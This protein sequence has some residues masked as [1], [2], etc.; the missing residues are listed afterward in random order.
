MTVD[1]ARE[2]LFQNARLRFPNGKGMPT[3]TKIEALED[4]ISDFAI[5]RAE[6]EE[7]R[8]HMNE[9]VGSMLD[10]WDDIEGWEPLAPR[11]RRRTT[12]AAR[13]SRSAPTWPPSSPTAS[14]W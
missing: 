10:E 14:G 3:A 11:A 2:L 8:L 9:A 4:Y 12:S 13:R 1:E 7:A 5:A 6:L